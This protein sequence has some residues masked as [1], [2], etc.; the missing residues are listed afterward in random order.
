MIVVIADLE[1]AAAVLL[2]ISCGHIYGPT[3]RR[4]PN[5]KMTSGGGRDRGG[6]SFADRPKLVPYRSGAQRKGHA[7]PCDLPCQTFECGRLNRVH[8]PYPGLTFFRGIPFVVVLAPGVAAVERWPG[9]TVVLK[10]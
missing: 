2:V 3:V 1:N 7:I 6:G 8:R 10:R 5:L 4:T 9:S